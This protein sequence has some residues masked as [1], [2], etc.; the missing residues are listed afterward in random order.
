MKTINEIQDSKSENKSEE[1]IECARA[2]YAEAEK[3]AATSELFFTKMALKEAF[4]CLQKAT[5]H[6][7]CE[8]AVYANCQASESWSNKVINS[9]F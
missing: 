2:I 9:E 5:C 3:K 4:D 6:S 1:Y 7:D 8:Y